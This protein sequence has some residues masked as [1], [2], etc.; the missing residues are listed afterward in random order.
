MKMKE[1]TVSFNVSDATGNST[2]KLT[3]PTDS[4]IGEARPQILESLELSECEFN[5]QPVT[6]TLYRSDPDE[7]ILSDADRVGDVLAEGQTV[8]PMKNITA[9]G[10][11]K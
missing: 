11:V 10:G 7:Q 4:T 2:A 5:G 6:W 3:V 1:K 8:V 9:G